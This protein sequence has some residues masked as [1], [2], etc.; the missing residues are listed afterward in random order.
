[1]KKMNEDEFSSISV[2]IRKENVFYVKIGN[3]I[4]F[5]ENMDLDNCIKI[6]LQENPEINR[7]TLVSVIY[8]YNFGDIQKT[9]KILNFNKIYGYVK[10]EVYLS[11]VDNTS[12][13]LYL[14]KKE[15]NHIQKILRKYKLQIKDIKLDFTSLLSFYTNKNESEKEILQ[16]GEDDSIR[17]KINYKKII[18][19]E[20]LDLTID[21]FRE[22]SDYDFADIEIISDN[23]QSISN[24]FEGSE[25]YSNYKF[26]E[27]SSN[28]ISN[29]KLFCYLILMFSFIFY[30]FIEY[31]KLNEDDIVKE[32]KKY[33][34][35]YEDYDNEFM[36]IFGDENDLYDAE[37]QYFD[38][39]NNSYK[40]E[41][42][43]SQITDTLYYLNENVLDE[44]EDMDRC[45]A[46]I[47]KDGEYSYIEEYIRENEYCV[48]A[49][50]ETLIYEKGKWKITISANSLINTSDYFVTRFKEKY[51][52]VNLLKYFWDH[53]EYKEIL[54][55]EFY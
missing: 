48:E 9:R 24:I 2:Y 17:A 36:S 8:H 53:E 49:N 32:I 11:H 3:D 29:K 30:F 14:P 47:D 34:M 19:V 12:L 51:D 46:F 22:N 28:N 52:N 6:I 33:E 38:E 15:I 44:H 27:R 31:N 50:I 4:S 25:I 1:M 20:K 40:K 7:Q 10:K 55:I 54:E 41:K 39:I 43:N 26:F 18:E 21:D 37:I 42:N 5:Y 35:L 45:L 23:E 13:S 16:L